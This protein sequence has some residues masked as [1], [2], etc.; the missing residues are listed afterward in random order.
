[1]GNINFKQSKICCISD[2]HLGVHQNNN[3]WH[4]I[5][6]EWATWLDKELKKKKIFDIMICGDLFHYRDEIAVN[7]LQVAKQFFD[8]LED[9]NIVMITGNHDCYYKDTSTV[10][11]LSLFGG[12]KNITVI[13]T[14][15]VDDIF[16][17][18][19]SFV[20]WGVNVKD[21]PKCDLV[22]GHFELTDF[23]MNNFKICDHGDSPESLL[24]KSKM[25]ITGHFHLRSERKYDEG[26]ILYLGNP[27]Q[28]D[29]GDAESRKGYYILDFD[30]IQNPKFTE[31]KISP[32]HIKLLLS[33]LI[34][35]D[36][37]TPELKQLIKGNII[38]LVIDKNIQGDD[39]DI[40]MIC[41]NNLK[42]FSITV[43]Y[44]IN[45]NK[46]SVEGELDFEYSG[47]DYESTIT[48]FV[49]MLDIN[50]KK[51]VIQYTI[52]LYKSCKE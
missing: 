27:F 10:N 13:D 33:D 17:K 24:N 18:R 28:M 22:F 41:L 44:E 52:D 34:K 31:N 9:Y 48:E 11:S 21:I 20:P 29:F 30:D 51:D 12:W 36:G 43:D 6:I 40:I 37:V 32:K 42:P 3:N 14:L 38:K 2:I 19:V 1:V 46:F 47:V 7:S 8:I 50:N 35:H 25:I 23:K 16:D 39:L 26:K 5:L 45:F 4:K 49:T 15:T